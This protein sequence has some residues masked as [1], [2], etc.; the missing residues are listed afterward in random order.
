MSGP[1]MRWALT[2]RVANPGLTQLIAALARIADKKGCS[3]RAQATL[4]EELAV[5]ERTIRLRLAVLE[6]LGVIQR[7]HRS[8][9]RG[10]RSSDLIRLRLDCQ[11]TI[12]KATARAVV[13]QVSSI[14]R[15]ASSNRQIST[16]QP[17]NSAGDKGREQLHQE[18]GTQGK[19]EPIYQSALR[20][21][22]A[23]PPAL[24]VV[25]GGRS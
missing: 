4:A 14:G 23:R 21:T 5:S 8:N 15:K 12:T 13:E 19:L 25:N 6:K 17:A 11:F 20:G 22:G 10:G 16:F 3:W 2:Q 9:G 18:E 24:S 1:A 7:A